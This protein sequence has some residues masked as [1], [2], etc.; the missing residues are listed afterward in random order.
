MRSPQRRALSL[1]EILI[2]LGIL[3]VGLAAVFEG[4]SSSRAAA[5]RMDVQ[6]CGRW[7]AQSVMERCL[8]QVRNSDNRYFQLGSS[9]E[10]ILAAARAGTWKQPFEALARPRTRFFEPD[11]TPGPYFDAATGPVWPPSIEV[12]EINFWKGFSYE[13]RVGF[14]MQEEVDGAPVPIDSDG[15]GKPE[16]D[17]A[18]LDVEVF[19]APADGS[20]AERPVSLLTTLAGAPDKPP[21]IGA[22]LDE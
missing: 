18:R 16:T 7:L 1:V 20:S 6:L 14:D 4:L 15:D 13:V 2:S 17:L 8:E 12:T 9:P 11:G 21:G 3:G 19:W 10:G 22:L 5:A